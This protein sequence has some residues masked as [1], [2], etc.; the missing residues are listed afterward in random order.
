MRAW[1][2]A[3]NESAK[4]WNISKRLAWWIILVPVIGAVL[5]GAARVNR[6]L[7]TFITMEDGPLEWPQF[8]CFA[9]AAIAGFAVA[10]KRLRAGH[11]WQALLFM[12]F[13]LATFLIAGEE[14]S[15][16]QRVFGWQ[17][18]AELAEINH[19][20]ET[21]V[22]NIRWVQELLGLLLAFASGI[23]MILPFVGKKFEFGKRWDQG[24]F[25]L[26]PP[27]FTA[28]CFFAMFAYKLIRFALF[29]D[30]EFT[31]TKFGEWPELCFAAGLLI[32][33]YLNYRRLA[34]QPA[35]AVAAGAEQ[36]R[37]TK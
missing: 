32:F 35:P 29:R 3:M 13:G 21:T 28:P 20:G 9:G 14:I 15:W 26:T 16:G 4:S 7:F 33:A 34:S 17:T 25:L 31:V 12:G 1:I 5:V 18:P 37:A 6:Q 23:A 30:S 8:F 27:L 22:H 2:N 36:A 10:F 19:Q 24:D 11:P